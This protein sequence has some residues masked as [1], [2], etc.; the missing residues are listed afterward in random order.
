MKLNK[1]DYVTHP[2]IEKPRKVTG[3]ISEDAVVLEGVP[4]TVSTAVLKKSTKTVK[5]NDTD[6]TKPNPAGG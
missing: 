6:T 3:V 5:S 2:D 4:G 1:S